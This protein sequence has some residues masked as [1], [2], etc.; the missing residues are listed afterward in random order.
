VQPGKTASA[1]VRVPN[2]S[3]SI[4]ALPWA[5]VWLDGQALG[6]TPLANV[7]VPLG[8]HEV[9][10]RHPQFGERR[11]TIMVTARTPVRVVVDLSK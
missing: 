3:V 4:N 2:G 10:W 11:Q 5:N 1:T 9:L 7:D 8:S 6:T